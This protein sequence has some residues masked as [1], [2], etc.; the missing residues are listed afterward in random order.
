MRSRVVAV[1]GDSAAVPVAELRDVL[2]LLRQHGAA[3]LREEYWRERLPTWLLRRFPAPLP[4]EQKGAWLEQ[5]RMASAAERAALERAADWEFS[6]WLYW[7][8][9][10]ND[11]WA[12]SDV[13]AD[14][15]RLRVEVE[16][17]RE[18]VPVKVL[19]WTFKAVGLRVESMERIS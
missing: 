5:W 14:G 11:I 2:V 15:R 9:A 10:G 19:E 6:Q 1:A 3:G 4:A 13:Q 8:G 18:P 7:F 17:D 16:H 12:L